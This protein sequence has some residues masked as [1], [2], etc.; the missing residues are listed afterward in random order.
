MS[1]RRTSETRFR[2]GDALE[3]SQRGGAHAARRV[4]SKACYFAEPIAILRWR[5]YARSTPPSRC[6]TSMRQDHPVRRRDALAVRRRARNAAH[7]SKDALFTVIYHLARPPLRLT[8]LG[9]SC[10]NGPRGPTTPTTKSPPSAN[11]GRT[12]V[13]I[14]IRSAL[15]RAAHA[16]CFAV[17]ADLNIIAG[18]SFCCTS[19]YTCTTTSKSRLYS[20]E[21]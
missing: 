20:N 15:H 6:A 4:P 11:H 19:S 5:A 13:E 12:A 14:R 7:S 10:P 8:I 2:R 17:L 1:A 9:P 16:P 21:K 18:V 3:R